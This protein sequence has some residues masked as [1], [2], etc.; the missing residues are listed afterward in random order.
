[1]AS[2]ESRILILLTSIILPG[3]PIPSDSNMEIRG[4]KIPSSGM[5]VETKCSIREQSQ[6]VSW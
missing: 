1:M 5:P 4:S 3:E 2:E 6:N